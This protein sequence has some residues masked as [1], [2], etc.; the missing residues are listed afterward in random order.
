[1]A[2]PSP[3]PPLARARE[4]AA[5]RVQDVD[6]IESGDYSSDVLAIPDFCNLTIT[7]LRKYRG[8]LQLGQ[9]ADLYMSNPAVQ[10][11]AWV[12]RFS[13]VIVKRNPQGKAKEGSTIAITIADLGCGKG[14]WLGWLHAKGYLKLT[15]VDL[16]PSDLGFAR[17]QRPAGTWIEQNVIRKLLN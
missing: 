15:G 7:G 11:G 16:S 2:R 8:K 3:A 17:Q 4:A 12:K 9:T 14:E 13:G 6:A 5:G 10:G 1:M